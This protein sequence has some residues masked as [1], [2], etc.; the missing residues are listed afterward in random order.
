MGDGSVVGEAVRVLDAAGLRASVL[1]QDLGTG[2]E[3]AIEPDVPYPLASVVKLPLLVAV[4]ERAAAGTIDLSA[5]VTLGSSE[6]T[7]GPT[8]LS[9]FAHSASV[10]V[11]DLLYLATCLSDD[12]AADALFALCPPG[13]VNATLRALGITDVTLRHPIHELHR[14]LASR[15]GP[16]EL[17]LA[18]SL[19]IR[20][21]TEGR[22]H[23]V[24]QLDVTQANAGT[25]RGLV[26]LLREV[27]TGQ[28]LDRATVERTRALLARNVLRNRLAPDLESDASTWSSK[29]GTF[30]HLR[31]EVGVL[32][33]HDGSAFA[34]AVLSESTVPAR[35]QPAAEQALGFAARALHDELRS[36][37]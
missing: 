9:Q 24:P 14:T 25:A 7:P 10:A 4:L 18:L 22:G 15:L 20:S 6:R 32:E 8:G 29:T 19:A 31:H 1:V 37:R 11:E 34:I 17:H 36:R 33:H 13:E 27:W 16:D 23:L 3:L 21:T 26:R 35:I 2:R 5:V 30:L 12:T 28:R